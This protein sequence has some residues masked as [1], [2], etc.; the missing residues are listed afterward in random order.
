VISL[1][2][3]QSLFG[4]A[5]RFLT[6]LLP[7]IANYILTKLCFSSFS[8]EILKIPEFIEKVVCLLRSPEPK[9][10]REAVCFITEVASNNVK[11]RN[12]LFDMNIVDLMQV[13][14]FEY[15]PILSQLSYPF[16]DSKIFIGVKMSC[17]KN[18]GLGRYW[19]HIIHVRKMKK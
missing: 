11:V 8:N 5:V 4:F 10:R 14:K 6:Y 3:K 19:C 13:L 1:F 9:V 2:L 12:K 18:I 16:K 17:S 7:R 15:N